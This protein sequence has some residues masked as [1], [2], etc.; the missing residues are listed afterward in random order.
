MLTKSDLQQIGNLID[1]SLD[2]K[3]NEALDKKLN[4]IKKDIKDILKYHDEY[5]VR[6][7]KRVEKIE[8]HLHI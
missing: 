6:L 4:P 2:K 3:L 1:K 5:Y 8:D 7:R